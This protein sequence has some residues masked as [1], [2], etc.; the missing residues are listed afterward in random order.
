M[1]ETERQIRR[2]REREAEEGRMAFFRKM[3]RPD[4][5]KTRG[6]DR[7]GVHGGSRVHQGGKVK[8]VQGRQQELGRVGY[9]QPE[10]ILGHHLTNIQPGEGEG[11]HQDEALPVHSAA[12]SRPE[13]FIRG[14]MSIKKTE[15]AETWP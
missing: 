4:R 12:C 6:I 1:R 9:G 3:K 13:G 5:R 10:K 11:H 7:R 2:E 14:R 15:G 8:Q